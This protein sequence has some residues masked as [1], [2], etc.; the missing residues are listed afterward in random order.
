MSGKVVGADKVGS[1]VTDEV[2]Q[3]GAF[4]FAIGHDRLMPGDSGQFPAFAHMGKGVVQVF[5]LIL[6]PPQRVCFSRGSN[7]NKYIT[8][9][10]L[11]DI[12][13][14]ASVTGSSAG[15]DTADVH[16]SY[17]RLVCELQR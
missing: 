6:S 1:Q 11:M 8:K 16:P 14:C 4:P 12:G 5:V 10:I 2:G 17:L 13:W 9:T 7:L 15:R 3:Q